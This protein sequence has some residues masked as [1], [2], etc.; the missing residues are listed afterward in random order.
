MLFF[1]DVVL[2]TFARFAFCHPCFERRAEFPGK[3]GMDSSDVPGFVRI[4]FHVI[5]FKRRRFAF[6]SDELVLLVLNG[7]PAA[8]RKADVA[9]E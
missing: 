3:F 1:L 5:E 7:E 9:I 6:G 8:C 4:A 2:S